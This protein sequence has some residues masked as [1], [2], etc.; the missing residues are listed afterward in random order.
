M[1]I[2]PRIQSQSTTTPFPRVNLEEYARQKISEVL[3]R[4]ALDK[5]NYQEPDDTCDC[6]EFVTNPPSAPTLPRRVS[7]PKPPRPPL[8]PILP[9]PLPPPPARFTAPQ[10][11]N[12]IPPFLPPPPVIFPGPNIDIEVDGPGGEDGDGGGTGGTG[13]TGDT[14]TASP[15]T[16]EGDD[17]WEGRI[18]CCN[19]SVV[20]TRVVSDTQLSL[21]AEES[22]HSG[23]F[24]NGCYPMCQLGRL[25]GFIPNAPAGFCNRSG[26]QIC[27][28]YARNNPSNPCYTGN[29]QISPP[30]RNLT[31]TSMFKS[32]P[33]PSQYASPRDYYIENL[34]Y[35]PDDF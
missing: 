33:L 24:R 14:T 16:G 2:D 21:G 28:C 26:I 10:L 1:A 34:D 32:L 23:E 6:D 12:A 13:G 15:P 30:G 4:K 22:T 8:P 19:T 18:S 35:F 20:E 31:T 3:R 9:P 17:F 27:K 25:T 11:P 5:T 29:G 7:P